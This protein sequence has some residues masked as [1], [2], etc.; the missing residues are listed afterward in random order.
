MKNLLFTGLALIMSVFIMSSIEAYSQVTAGPGNTSGTIAFGRK[1]IISTDP[2]GNEF[3]ECDNNYPLEICFTCG[4]QRSNSS[5][6][7]VFM[8]DAGNQEN[9]LGW[10]DAV[11]V[12]NNPVQQITKRSGSGTYTSY[13]AFKAVCV[14]P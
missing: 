11:L 2:A 4:P 3:I 9:G 8:H 14:A 13:S 12:W 10:D 1:V 5:L 7:G 6:Q